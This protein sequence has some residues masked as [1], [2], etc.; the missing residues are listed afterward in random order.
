MGSP[1]EIQIYA[2]TAADGQKV[3]A[4]LA[5]D[6]AR[7]EQRYSR[8]RHDSD[9]SKI[10]QVALTGGGIDVDAETA[11]LFDYAAACFEA[12]G[13]LFDVTS[14]VLRRVWRFHDSALPDPNA[15]AQVLTQVGWQRIK[16]KAPQLEFT[17]PGME[18]DFGGIVKEYAA[19]R[20]AALCWE[21]GVHHGFINLGGDIR[22]VGP[23]PD[24]SPW[25]I[26]IRDPQL[27]GGIT[28]TVTLF[29]G[30]LATS[31]DYERCLI[32]DGKRYGHVLSPLTGWPV[33][34][35]VSVSV[36]ADLCTVAG[37]TATI[38]MLKEKQGTDWLAQSGLPYFWIDAAGA[39]GGTL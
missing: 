23:H 9:L 8:Y 28:R 21:Q 10:N 31:G 32:V 26:G 34:H 39:I 36:V 18:I 35:L 19:D 37:S 4:Q 17:V 13:G 16:W 25:N 11:S 24:G 3:T 33:R 15:I 22:I 38:A 12:S 29:R 30:G 7:L 20:A 5:A 6:V 14:G 27:R 2:K 1:C